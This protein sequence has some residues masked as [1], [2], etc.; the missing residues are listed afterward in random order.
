MKKTAGQL[1]LQ[2]SQ[3]TT[4]YKSIDVGH[5]LCDDIMP[6]LIECVQKHEKLID[7]PIFCVVMVLAGDPLIK[8]VLRRKF[9]AW[10]YLPKPRPNQAVFLYRKATQQFQRLWVLPNAWTMA[11]LSTLTHVDPQ[12]V[13]MKIWSEA[14]YKGN[15][16][17]T[18]R[19]ENN[20]KLESEQEYLDI[21]REKLLDACG[22]KVAPRGAD[23]FDFSKINVN[24][25]VDA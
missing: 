21:N 3:D 5:A 24:K 16:W 11:C 7:E 10:P 9:Y 14:F 1:S 25:V 17:E 19:A 6:Q 20:L 15:F 13:T 8:N 22:D 2:A 12:L 23:P 4:K 18:I